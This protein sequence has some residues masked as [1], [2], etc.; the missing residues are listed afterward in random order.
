[1]LNYGREIASL[2]QRQTCPRESPN[3]EAGYL[4]YAL[5]EDLPL[6]DPHEWEKKFGM[7]ARNGTSLSWQG[8]GIVVVAKLSVRI[9]V[10]G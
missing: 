8:R 3:I 6:T 1:M 9:L 7:G 10:C 2:R 4:L 5:I